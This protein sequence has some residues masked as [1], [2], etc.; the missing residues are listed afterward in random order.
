MEFLQKTIRTLFRSGYLFFRYVRLHRKQIIQ[1]LFGVIIILIVLYALFIQAPTR[2]PIKTTI[3]VPEGATLSA[4]AE[5]LKEQNVVRSGFLYKVFNVLSG[6]Q[7]RIQA[8]D[9]YFNEKTDLFGITA[10]IATGNFGLTPVVVRV[11]EGA[12]IFSIGELMEGK[13]DRFDKQ[14][15]ITR[16]LEEEAEGYLF[17]DTYQ[18][19]PNVN[20]EKVYRVLRDTF[21]DKVATITPQIE[22]FGEPLKDIVIMASIIEKESANNFVERQ[23]IAGILWNRIN[24]GMALQVDAV[25]PYINGKNTF[26]LSTEDLDIDSPYNTYK[27]PGLPIGPIANPSLDSLLAAVTPI[28]TNYIF[29]LHDLSGNV[30]YSETFEG[31]KQN[32]F[33]HLR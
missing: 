1:T 30:H 24:I 10:H 8:G 23:T 20:E 11:P 7:T 4:T 21:D 18:F 12:T 2:F 5:I 15:F 31:H 26:E 16:A 9:Y 27:Y 32:K 13:L 22:A 14:A 29:Y 6:N 33:R 19:L 28:E 17:P 25:F 3:T